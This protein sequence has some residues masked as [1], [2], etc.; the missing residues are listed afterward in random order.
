MR[1]AVVDAFHK[2]EK[3][4]H[5]MKSRLTEAERGKRSTE[6]AL[7]SVERQVEGQRVLLR[8]GKD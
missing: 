6:V 5:E 7:D 3:R 8:Q 2:A 1:I 4:N